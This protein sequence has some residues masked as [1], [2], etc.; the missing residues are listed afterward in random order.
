MNS[1]EVLIVGAGPVGLSLALECAR[2]DVAFQIIDAAAQPSDKSKALAIWSAAQEAFS[3]MGVL[4]KM[5]A[6]AFLGGHP[7]DLARCPCA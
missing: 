4:E 7:C 1:T 2:H 6:E 3:A 5:R